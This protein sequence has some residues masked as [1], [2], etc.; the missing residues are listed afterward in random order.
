MSVGINT[1]EV[2]NI[3]EYEGDLCSIV[4]KSHTKPGKGGAYFQVEMRSVK[5]GNKLNVRFNSGESVNKIRIDDKPC[6]VIFQENDAICVMDDSYDQIMV[7]KAF[8]NEDALPFLVDG[9]DIVL[10]MHDDTVVSVT[11]P[12][13]ASGEVSECEPVIKGQTVTSSY[14]PSILSNGAR[15]MVPPFVGVGDKIVVDLEK[16]EYLRREK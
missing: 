1:I 13:T 7:D 15:V 4:K 16:M 10:G 6:K 9:V 11:M 14:K 3:I 2:G 8:I 5:K 12:K